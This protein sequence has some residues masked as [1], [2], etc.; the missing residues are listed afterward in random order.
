MRN[1]SDNFQFVRISVYLLE[2]C[3][4]G[5][6]G[7]Y[8]AAAHKRHPLRTYSPTKEV[9]SMSCFKKVLLMLSIVG[10]INWGISRRL[11]VQRCGVAA[12]RQ[13]E[14]AVPHRVHH[15]GAVVALPD[16]RAVYGR[17]QSSRIKGE[18]FCQWRGSLPHRLRAGASSQRGPRRQRV[19]HGHPLFFIKSA[20]FPACCGGCSCRR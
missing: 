13:H 20:A 16:P 4:P 1:R 19:P 5:M 2:S 11:G 12:G 14:L 10:G 15:R 6:P 9:P 7:P 3:G 8:G 18:G 17:P